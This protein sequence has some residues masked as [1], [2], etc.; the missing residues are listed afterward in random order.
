MTRP[1]RLGLLLAA[2]GL[3]VGHALVFDFVNDDAFISFRYADNLVRHGA[4]VFNPGERVE[5]YTNFLWTVLIAGVLALKGEPV[6]WSKVLSIGLGIG[7]LW[8]I[9]RFSARQERDGASGWDALGPFLL[10]AAPAYA[11]WSTG[12]LE[13]QLFTFTLTMG[14]VGYLT[15]RDDGYAGTP[16]SGVWFALAAMTRPE[17][18]LFFGLTG[19][20]RLGEMLFAQ[21]TWKPEKQDW[22]WGLGFALVFGPYYLWRYSFY[23]YPFPN[24]YY[25]KTGA[26]D[27]WAP[28]ARYLW[29]WVKDHALYA[30]FPLALVVRRRLPGGRRGRLWTLV[31]LYT[32]ALCVHVARVG[33]DFMGLHRFFVPLMPLLALVIAQALRSLGEWL[34]ARGK[35][36]ALAGVAL[37]AALAGVGGWQVYRIDQQAMTVGSD[38]GVDRI[39]WLKQFAEQCAAIGRWIAENTP[40]DARLA[41]TAAGTIPFYARRYTYDILLLN[42]DTE[43]VK[44]TPAHGN[45]PGHTK[46]ASHAQIMAQDIDYLIYH[47][48]IAERRPG[49]RRGPSGYEWF[50][51]QVPGMEPPWWG[52]F[53]RR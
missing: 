20:H 49:P 43:V 2:A 21:R 1:V 22:I 13:T 31:L 37:A 3:L 39:G 12:G 9:A 24:T 53:R 45:R 38:A 8:A 51:V 50:T 28:G 26:K 14:W 18:M 27:F 23:G 5:G 17:G 35:G 11:C 7:S 52:V 29:S 40:E 6:F 47:P 42:V 48:T 33:G 32:A 15:E 4:L 16:T 36:P 10:A 19:L 34:A 41:T 30:L 25:V 44:A 46:A